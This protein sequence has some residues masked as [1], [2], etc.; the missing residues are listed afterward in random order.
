MRGFPFAIAVERRNPMI[1]KEKATFPNPSTYG[2]MTMFFPFLP[3]L[4]SPLLLVQKFECGR[5][6]DFSLAMVTF[7]AESYPPTFPFDG[8]P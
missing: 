2:I 3:P 6:C 8:V 1:D 5:F 4:F 7:P